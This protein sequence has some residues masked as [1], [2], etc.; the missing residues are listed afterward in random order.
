M[1]RRVTWLMH[2][3]I[4]ITL[5]VA[6][7]FAWG[8]PATSAA[9][10]YPADF[11]EST[12]VSGLTRP[13]AIDW[14]PD[15]RM[16]IA[17]QSGLVQVLEPGAASPTTLLDLRDRVNSYGTRGLLGLA[18]DSNFSSNGY[19]YLL[20][21]YELYPL[22][23]DGSSPAVAQLL[24][25][26]LDA[27]DA[28]AEEKVLLGSSVSGPCP[29]ADNGVDCIPADGDSH[30]IGTVRSAPD[31]TLW[32]GSGDGAGYEAVDQLAFRSYDEAG[33]AGKIMH[34]DRAGHGLPGH[35]FC[36]GDGDLG[37][38]CTKLYAKGFRN[39]FRFTLRPDGG[40]VVADVGWTRLEEIDLLTSGG[41]SYGWPCYEASEHTSGPTSG[42][43][44]DP[45]CPPEYG[46]EG[47]ADAHTPPDYEYLHTAG[48]NSIIAGPEYHGHTYPSR[49][50]GL[51]FFGDYNAGFVKTLTRDSNGQL[52][53]ADFADGW[54]G[55][56][57]EQGPDGNLVY[58]DY[59]TGAA[60]TGA[61]R[62]IVGPPNNAPAAAASA[63][64]TTGT[65]PLT[66]NFD[67]SG[68]SDLDGDSLTYSWDFG[69][70]SPPST[71]PSPTHI[72]ADGGSYQA[73][74]TVDDGRGG[75]ANAGVGIDVANPPV[76]PAPSTGHQPGARLAPRDRSGPTFWFDPRSG[77]AAR[78]GI[79]SG[80]ARDSSGL[81]RLAVALG[82]R[83]RR[84]PGCR[85]WLKSR[86]R[87][88]RG[89]RRCKRP[90]Y[91]RARLTPRRDGS[92][93]WRIRLGGRMHPGP[94]RLCL[95]GLDGA[96]NTGRKLVRFRVATG[97]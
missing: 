18:V 86:G 84:G 58:A 68:S 72:Y 23:P 4:L 38:V 26:Q 2:G 78:R 6:G 36:P 11:Y 10:T 56:D 34:I 32:V 5:L 64:N 30:T 13:T 3:R 47:T 44:D 61:V 28:V 93:R 43:K 24:R 75:S 40:V 46:K 55:V 95:R 16:L 67:G 80:T 25:V 96:G 57:L 45:K 54:R 29:A 9:A 52:V 33:L 22:T 21:T 49:F 69:D 77:L 50:R 12:L 17:Q 8:A 81:T 20:Y 37:H 82:R 74:L 53:A 73:T 83:S 63:D 76:S 60:G 65:T 39:P 88:S 35:S 89:T 14:I 51:I 1:D 59:G 94:Y 97:A 85:W 42:Y 7:C 15:G 71:A 87:L 62:E 41:K 90:R 70:G 66:V 91:I 19:L 48:G 27:S 79:L 31:G 92:W